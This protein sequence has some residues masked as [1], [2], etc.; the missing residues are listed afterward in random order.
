[1]P[2]RNP[3]TVLL[4]GGPDSS[5]PACHRHEDGSSCGTGFLGPRPSARQQQGGSGCMG[6]TK[7]T[8][9]EREGAEGTGQR[10]RPLTGTGAV[11]GLGVTEAVKSIGGITL[12]FSGA[13]YVGSLCANPLS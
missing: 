7:A 3:A 6:C 12:F 4:V 8:W 2:T 10:G 5:V 13:S 1:M 9:Q 11:W